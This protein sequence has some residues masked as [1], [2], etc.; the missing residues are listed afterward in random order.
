[1]RVLFNNESCI[2]FEEKLTKHEYNVPDSRIDRTRWEILLAAVRS[3]LVCDIITTQLQTIKIDAEEGFSDISSLIETIVYT[4]LGESVEVALT[5]KELEMEMAVAEYKGETPSKMKT[6]YI[7]NGRY[8]HPDPINDYMYDLISEHRNLIMCDAK[9]IN[10]VTC[11]CAKKIL[12][13]FYDLQ[14]A[15]EQETEE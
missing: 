4:C 15:Q 9:P 6:M 11:E 5:D 7:I 10:D 13:C 2:D 14:C 1:M 12:S 8:W 3:L